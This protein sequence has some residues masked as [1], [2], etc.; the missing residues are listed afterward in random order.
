MANNDDTNN[1][2]DESVKAAEDEM[3]MILNETRPKHFGHGV[4]SGVESI[5]GGGIG[6]IGIAVL[7]PVQGAAIGARQAGILGG[8]VG[9][10]GGTVVGVVHAA[11][12]AAGG[13]FL[14]RRMFMFELCV[15]F[16]DCESCCSC[17]C[18]CLFE[19]ELP[20]L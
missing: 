18:C 20:V 6:A 5:V 2:I 3:N 7:T 19:R 1:D 14:T 9:V 13:E 16:D 15:C 11:N 4:W 8:A 10:L 17:S 12:V